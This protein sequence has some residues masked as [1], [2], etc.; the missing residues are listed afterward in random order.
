MSLEYVTLFLILNHVF[1]LLIDGK[2]ILS[3]SEF[4]CREFLFLPLNYMM[5]QWCQA[6]AEA[7]TFSF[8]EQNK[9][10]NGTI[11]SKFQPCNTKSFTC[12]GILQLHKNLNIE[13]NTYFSTAPASLITSLPRKHSC[14]CSFHFDG[15]NHVHHNHSQKVLYLDISNSYKLP[16]QGLK[17]SCEITKK[18]LYCL[19]IMPL[20]ILFQVKKVLIQ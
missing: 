6:Q 12:T 4:S 14:A 5:T 19:Q 1:Y 20:I 18:L 16:Q 9:D 15:S 17:F 13:Q 8:F 11:K 3:S 2:L 10:W 7:K